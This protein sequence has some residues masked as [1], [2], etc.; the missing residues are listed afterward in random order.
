MV[1]INDLLS[2]LT[3]CVPYVLAN[4]TKCCKQITSFIDV[5]SLQTDLNN[6][7]K[8]CHKN[9]LSFNNCKSCRLRFLKRARN[10]TYND[11]TING[12]SVVSQDH[13]KGLGVILSSDLLWT[14]HYHS[15][16]AKAYQILGLIRRTFSSSV[17]T[18]FKKLLFLSLTNSR[19][20]YCSQVWRPH[21]IKDINLLEK[22]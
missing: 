3:S 5:L 16:T 4:D 15:I 10:V 20:T 1:Y 6:L 18:R 19:P 13:C 17:P 12:N 14:V 2:A 11:Y 22:V 7:S 9:E 21:Y 8:W